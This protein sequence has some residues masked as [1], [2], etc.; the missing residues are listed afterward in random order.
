MLQSKVAMKGLGTTSLI[1]TPE[2]PSQ[3]D[4]AFTVDGRKYTHTTY[5][6]SQD[7]NVTCSEFS[8]TFDTNDVVK[9]IMIISYSLI[10]LLYKPS[11]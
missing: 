4:E 2:F 9:V 3:T 5:T 1:C 7:L 11:V 6:H 8:R 10:N